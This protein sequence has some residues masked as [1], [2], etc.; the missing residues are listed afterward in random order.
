M[1]KIINYQF[2]IINLRN[3][4]RTDVTFQQNDSL[5]SRVCSKKVM[6]NK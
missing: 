3:F 6:F 5:Y 1:G 2:S 4:F